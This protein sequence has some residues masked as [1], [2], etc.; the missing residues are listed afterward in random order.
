M[1]STMPCLSTVQ[2]LANSPSNFEFTKI[3]SAEV[4]TNRERI[5]LVEECSSPKRRLSKCCHTATLRLTAPSAFL[6]SSHLSWLYGN[7]TR[8]RSSIQSIQMELIMIQT[9]QIQ[10]KISGGNTG[11]TQIRIRA[12][13]AV[14]CQVLQDLGYYRGV[15]EPQMNSPTTDLVPGLVWAR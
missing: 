1:L 13:R 11:N 4:G 14:C 9:K 5:V 12:L 8:Y 7:W 2:H 3:N 10:K 15:W 6:R